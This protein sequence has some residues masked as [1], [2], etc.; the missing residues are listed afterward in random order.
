MLIIILGTASIGSPQ[1]AAEGASSL[2]ASPGLYPHAPI[3]ILNDSGFNDPNTI[4]SGT[5]TATDPYIIQD[6]VIRTKTTSGITLQ[7]TRAHVIIRNLSVLGFSP[8]PGIFILDAANVTI[9]SVEV[10]GFPAG[11]YIGASGDIKVLGSLIG[12]NDAYGVQVENSARVRVEG[13]SVTDNNVGVFLG[14]SSAVVIDSRF[15]RNHIGIETVRSAGANVS[16]NVITTQ[17]WSG[18]FTSGI[19]IRS[20]DGSFVTGNTVSSVP[21]FPVS[22]DASRRVTFT[23]NNIHHNGW[24]VRLTSSDGTVTHNRFDFNG[25]GSYDNAAN[26][27]DAGYPTGGNEWSGYTGVDNCS[28]PA[29]NDC[30]V[31]DGIG[32]TPYVASPTVTDRYPLILAEPP[33]VVEISP[34][35]RNVLVDR[36]VVFTSVV[37]NSKWDVTAYRWDFGDGKSATGVTTTHVYHTVGNFSVRL[38]VTDHRGVSTEVAQPLGVWPDVAFVTVEHSSGFRLPIPS[39]W[40]VRK[41][42]QVNG[43]TI[44][45]VALGP[46]V[47]GFR[48]NVIVLAASDPSARE[49][50][51]YLRFAM[52]ETVR[53]AQRNGLDITVTEGPVFLT[54]SGHRAVAFGLARS[55]VN[56]VQRAVIVVSSAH[57][58]DWLLLLSVSGAASPHTNA[59]FDAVV[60]G[61]LITA[62][63]TQILF[64]EIGGSIAAVVVAVVL[65]VVFVVRRRRKSSPSIPSASAVPPSG[66]GPLTGPSPPPFN[67]AAVRFCPRCG[68]AGRENNFCTNCGNPLRH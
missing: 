3:S 35:T 60:A 22:I 39:D 34:S 12:G 11:V 20:S 66:I 9:S 24:G 2:P 63:P 42:S 56:I 4:Y 47:N 55:S 13:I 15:E 50:E 40:E 62:I 25:N 28:G 49:D 52:S 32:D 23:G 17:P 18:N 45:V 48:T 27:W 7:S 46:T 36:T 58:Q 1:I 37:R 29:Q 43:A 51:F 31:S 6:W 67:P 57:A 41:D 14:N 68:T 10:I 64:L 53:T 30:S 5:G 26:P 61:F 44:P 65:L 21:G 59:T 8:K 19:W 16:R 33:L 54:V 38:N